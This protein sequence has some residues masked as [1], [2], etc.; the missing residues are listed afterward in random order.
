MNVGQVEKQIGW[1]GRKSSPGGFRFRALACWL[2]NRSVKAELRLRKACFNGG[3]ASGKWGNYA[4]RDSQN[5]SIRPDSIKQRREIMAL[6]PRTDHSIAD[7]LQREPMTVLHPA[8]TTPEP[9]N[10][11]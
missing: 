4:V 9:T 8:S 7:C 11:P 6:A 5:S 2:L 3:S 1:A 10:N